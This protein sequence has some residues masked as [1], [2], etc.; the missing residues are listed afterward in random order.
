MSTR[1]LSAVILDMDG[2]MLDVE[3]VARVAWKLAMRDRGYEIGDDVYMRLVGRT[4]RQAEE[5]LKEAFGDDLPFEDIRR[6]KRRY[7]DK[8]VDRYGISIKPGLSDLL[9]FLEQVGV[10]TAV[11]TSSGRE[12]VD[13]KLAAVGLTGRF[14]V[15]V[16]GDD[17]ERGKPAPDIFLTAAD[18]LRAQPERCLVLEDSE[19]GVRAAHAAG[20]VAVMVPDIQ[21]PSEEVRGMACRVLPSLREALPFLM[22]IIGATR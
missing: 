22:E 2:L 21:P 19:A 13:R 8:H 16:C 3:R 9:D 6:R 4:I 1:R 17:V 5:I 7:I 20:M 12:S 14:D 18:R 11:A 10:P 15:V